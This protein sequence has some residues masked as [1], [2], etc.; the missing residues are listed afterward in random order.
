MGINGLSPSDRWQKLLHLQFLNLLFKIH[1]SVWEKNSTLEEIQLINKRTADALCSHQTNKSRGLLGDSRSSDW[2]Q[3][4]S[5]KLRGALGIHRM[6]WAVAQSPLA[7]HSWLG[8]AKKKPSTL[9]VTYK[10]K[11]ALKIRYRNDLGYRRQN[12]CYFTTHESIPIM[13]EDR[14][15]FLTFT[16]YRKSK[17]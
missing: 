12:Q 7:P 5:P 10:Q 9:Y 2:L 16:L 6:F 1:C 14:N 11:R 13:R 4:G 15:C 17:H 8:P 3:R